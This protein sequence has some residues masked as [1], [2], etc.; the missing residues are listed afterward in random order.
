LSAAKRYGKS[1]L[2][3]ACQRALAIGAPRR[4]SI[5]SILKKGLDQQP[6]N[7]ATA[8]AR[9][10]QHDNIRGAA[11]YQTQLTTLT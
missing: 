11:H 9:I 3:A 2:E 8:P 1:R 7:S 6:L 5:L 4:R 10:Q